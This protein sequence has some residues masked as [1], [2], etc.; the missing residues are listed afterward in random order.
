M[1]TTQIIYGGLSAQ[2]MSATTYQNLPLGIYGTGLTFNTGNYDL[3]IDGS[4]G[5][6]DTVSLSILASDLTVTGGT[7]NTNTGI[8]T[9]TNNTGGTFNVSGFLTGLTDTFVTGGTY[10][11]G[12]ITFT[13]TS[14]GTF[15]VSGL[16]TSSGVGGTMVTGGTYSAGTA[17]FT[18]STGGTFNVTGFYDFPTSKTGTTIHFSAATIFGTYS[19]PETGNITEN[20]TNSK[21]GVV[22]KIYHNSSSSPSVPVTWVLLG[23]TTYQTNTLN[24]IYAEWSEGSRVEY[25]IVR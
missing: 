8:A 12:T 13:N 16:T 18:N 2:T 22:Q 25:W 14:G 4:N 7:Y 21:L 3:T 9:F 17:T 23:G 15:E 5:I 1:A 20:L 6:L 24:I 10:S 19:V 11:A